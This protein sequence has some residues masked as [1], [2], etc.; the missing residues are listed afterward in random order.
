MSAKTTTVKFTLQVARSSAPGGWADEISLDSFKDDAYRAEA[1]R[2]MQ[3]DAHRR[4]YRM[5]KVT[6]TTEVVNE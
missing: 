3:R 4:Q 6:T 1:L 5:V 2:I